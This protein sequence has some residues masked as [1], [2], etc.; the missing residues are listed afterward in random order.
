MSAEFEQVISFAKA[1]MELEEKDREAKR[2]ARNKKARE[3]YARKKANGTLV[4]AAQRRAD[5]YARITR[6]EELRDAY[7]EEHRCA[8]GDPGA[9]PPCD[10]CEKCEGCWDDD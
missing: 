5:E 1:L 3:R 9:N 7:A 4:T 10:H 6:E 8:C 2:L